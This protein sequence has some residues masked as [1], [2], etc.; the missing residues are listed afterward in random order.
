MKHVWFASVIALAPLSLSATESYDFSSG[1]HETG[2]VGLTLT[3][4]I[5]RVSVVRRLLDQQS[6]DR[7]RERGLSQSIYV[8]S[9]ERVSD[10]FE[11]PIPRDIA[12]SSRGE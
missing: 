2:L 10:T 3:T 1:S 4:E 5:N 6:Q 9:L 8:R 7:E 11:Q 12:E